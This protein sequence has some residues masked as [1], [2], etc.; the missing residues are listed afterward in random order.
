[1]RT[2]IARHLEREVLSRGQNTTSEHPGVSAGSRVP[3]GQQTATGSAGEETSPRRGCTAAS[4]GAGAVTTI[5]PNNVV[6][7]AGLTAITHL[8]LAALCDPGDG[9]LLPSPA[10]AGF[11]GAVSAASV[12][13]VAIRVHGPS[14]D[15]PNDID[16]CISVASLDSAASAAEASGTPVRVLLLASPSNPTGKLYASGCFTLLPVACYYRPTVRGHAHTREYLHP[17]A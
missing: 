6:C 3:D 11:D 13:A 1:M 12:G 8:V 4:A 17:H 15:N 9:V 14:P 16:A 2:A 7:S 10:Y 5:D